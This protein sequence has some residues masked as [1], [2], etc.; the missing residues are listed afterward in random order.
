MKA[1]SGTRRSPRKI[2]LSASR[3]TDIPAFYMPWFTAGIRSGHF[4]VINPYN[5]SVTR[6]PSDPETVHSVVFWSKDFGPFLSGGYGESLEKKGYGLF[7]NFTV[8]SVHPLLE[9]NVPPLIGRLEQM[10]ALSERFGPACIQ[11]RFDPICHL[12]GK[13]PAS[14]PDNLGDFRRIADAA[15]KCGI[16]RCITSFVDEYAKV[17]RRM[18]ALD[19]VALR[20]PSMERKRRLL[21]EMAERLDRRNIR[22]YT[23]CERE[24]LEGLPPQS[25]IGRA[26]CIP[27]KLL[28]SLYGEGISTAR[29]TGQ[30]ARQGCGCSVSRDIGSYA[31]HPCHHNCLYC[32]ANPRGP[33][34]RS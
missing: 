26:A 15:A 4:E 10:K 17:H 24:V 18:A 22:L 16:S 23:C 19:G 1:A 7:F 11:W 32:Y 5:R 33:A 6:V 34:S 14:P 12:E 25:G 20:I 2:V 27:G 13:G 8:N 21:S 3:R 30:R 29:D 28:V 31:L 9:P